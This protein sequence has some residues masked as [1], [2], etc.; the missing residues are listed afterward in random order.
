MTRL[1]TLVAEILGVDPSIVTAETGPG[2]IPQ[3]DSMA[4]MQL[5]AA[6]E[7]SYGVQFT[8]EEIPTIMSIAE[9]A[10]L[11]EGKGVAIG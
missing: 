9:L 3:W 7:E 2:T 8:I 5:V 11:L 4:H 10:A 1:R 6:I